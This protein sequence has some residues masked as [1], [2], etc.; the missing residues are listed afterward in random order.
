MLLGQE[1]G[2]RED[3]EGIVTFG[4]LCGLSNNN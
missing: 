3:V 4:D 2:V 1:K